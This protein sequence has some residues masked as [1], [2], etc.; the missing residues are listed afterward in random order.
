VE[1]SLES[2]VH[3]PK[4]TMNS[5]TWTF[6]WRGALGASFGYAIM[7]LYSLYRDPYLRL[8]IWGFLIFVFLPVACGALVGFSLWVIQRKL[9]MRLNVISR[10]IEGAAL[11]TLLFLPYIYFFEHGMATLNLIEIKRLI[12]DSI[13]SGIVMGLPAGLIMPS[14]RRRAK[15][16][17]PV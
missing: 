16:V 5:G 17:K 7:V 6:I 14:E 15:E 3:R 2:A 8:F 13:Y 10:A 9:G 4:Q 1:A 11:M 12:L